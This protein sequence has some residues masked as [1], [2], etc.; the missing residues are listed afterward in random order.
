MAR[1]TRQSRRHDEGFALVEAMIAVTLAAIAATGITVAMGAASKGTATGRMTTAGTAVARTQIEAMRSIGSSRMAHL[2]G[3]L[4]EDTAVVNS[5]FDPDGAGP[6]TAEAIISSATGITSNTTTTTRDAVT[7]TSKTYITSAANSAKRVTIL[8]TWLM[9]TQPRKASLSTI[10]APPTSPIA[11][12]ADAFIG[13]DGAGDLV[14]AVSS[15]ARRGGGYEQQTGA[16]ST[17]LTGWTMTSTT[18]TA[19]VHPG[20][21]HHARTQLSSGSISMTGITVT[22]TGA[23]VRAD[24]TA[25][26]SVTSTISGSVTVNGTLFVNPV[27]GTTITVN[28]WQIILADEET[29]V[30]GARAVSLVRLLGPVGE[31]YRMGWVWLTPVTP[32]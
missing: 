30:R 7:Y 32:W 18:T 13:K 16:T 15:R 6:L 26:G 2:T 28:G 23:D 10:V 31:D 12:A 25:S 17:P 1:G 21:S 27:G 19:E 14:P 4:A 11:A 8:V 24:A 20:V 3:S 5:T 22:V 9:G 29:D